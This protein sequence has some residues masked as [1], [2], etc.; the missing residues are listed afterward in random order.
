M[1]EGTFPDVLKV[2]KVTPVF[3]KDDPEVLGNYRPVSTLPI[4]GKIFEKVIYSRIYNFAS[5]QG[6]FNE[7]QF[8][9]RKS[10]STSHAIN[11]SV[12]FINQSLKQRKHILG[13]FID[14]SKAFDTIDHS[15]LLAKLNHYGIRGAANSLIQSYL[16]DRTQYVEALGEK[17]DKLTT[18][19]GVPQGSV[20]GP[21]L[22][23]LYIN[24]ISNSSKLGEFIL[25]A[26][27]TNIFVEGSSPEDAYHKGNIILKSVQQY[28][29]VNKLHINLSKC[30]YIHFKP[31][32]YPSSNPSPDVELKLDDFPIKKKKTAKFLGVIIDENLSWD[33]HIKSLKQKLS[34]ATSTLNR[35]R[36]SL[37]VH[38]YRELYYTLFESHL[39]YCISVWGGTTQE[40]I[41][42]LWKAQ[43]LCIRTLFGD[44][45]AFQDKFMTS[46]RTRSIDSQQLGQDFFCLEH[47]KPIFKQ[48]N[49]LSIHNLYTYHCFMECFKILKLR[50]PISLF[51][52]YSLST[53]KPTTITPSY[54]SKTFT[55]RSTYLW[56][57]LAPKMKVL[58]YSAKISVV[59]ANLKKCIFTNQHNQTKLMWTT[60]DFNILKIVGR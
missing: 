27:D 55:S 49:I 51:K 15:T 25:F 3:K 52:E 46:C 14:L 11:K 54:P 59:K 20:L 48:Q 57:I 2:G 7:N 32:R 53:R 37:P 28:M 10:H 38:T 17:S 23:L 18:I 31:N 39:T 34:Y 50:S 26:D 13:I 6:I 41:S 5:S 22:F 24:D 56:N 1:N 42:K 45:E 60:E 8:G 33:A 16:S 29:L 44:R 40:N 35:I 47:T 12:S 58:D 9:F 4:F 30:C 36:D 43:K 19:Y 21:L